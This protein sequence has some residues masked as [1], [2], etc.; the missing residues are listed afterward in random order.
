MEYEFFSKFKLQIRLKMCVIKKVKNTV[1]WSYVIEGLKGEGI[2]VKFY[3]KRLQ[4]TSQTEF[5]TG[6]VTKQKG[7]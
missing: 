7:D 3:E 1:S 4:K 2:V 6:K 5:R